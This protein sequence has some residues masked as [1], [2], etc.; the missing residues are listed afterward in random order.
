MAPC[1]RGGGLGHA[2]ERGRIRQVVAAAAGEATSRSTP[3]VHAAAAA[4]AAAGL[5]GPT[6]VGHAAATPVGHT[7]VAAATPVAGPPPVGH[8]ASAKEPKA[9]TPWSATGARQAL[10]QPAA[11]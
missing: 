2:L 11:A 5:S 7:A 10:P 3:V 9:T 6:P 4:A 1:P 8:A